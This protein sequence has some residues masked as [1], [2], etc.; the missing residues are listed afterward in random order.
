MPAGPHPCLGGALL[1]VAGGLMVLALGLALAGY[2]RRR[3]E[4]AA[5]RAPPGPPAAP[6]APLPAEAP[7]RPLARAEPT[8]QSPALL[9]PAARR[10]DPDATTRPYPRPPSSRPPLPDAARTLSQSQNDLANAIE[11]DAQRMRE[12]AG[13]PIPVPPEFRKKGP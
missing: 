6:P 11:A 3:D 9:A 10:Y 2:L 8:P 12:S 5:R 7:T 4:L 1:A 13:K